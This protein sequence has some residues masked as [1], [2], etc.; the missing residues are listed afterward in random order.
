[1]RVP[2]LIL[3]A[4][5][6]ALVSCK[7][8]ETP[9]SVSGEGSSEEAIPDDGSPVTLRVKW[10]LGNRYTQRMEVTGDTETFVPQMPKPML[11]R[12]NLNQDYGITVLGER[13]K[14]G[15]ELELEVEST[16]IDVTMD[17][18]PVV[19]LDT[20]AEA[21]P[22]ETANP[23]IAAFRQIVGAK[24]KFVLNESNHVE[25]V[26][27][28]KE[29]AAKATSAGNPQGRAAMQSMFTEDYFK[30]MVDFQ[31]G[32]PAKAVKVGDSWPL[33]TDLAM[34]I[35]AVTLDINYT[36]KGWENREKRKCAA[37]DF[38]GTMSSKGGSNTGPAGMS[39][40]I[41]SGK[42][43]GKEWF[44]PELGSMIETVIHQDMVLHMSMPMGRAR[45]NA[46]GAGGSRSITNNTKQKITIK[47]VE[48]VSAAK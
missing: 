6:L 42:L 45:T 18:K 21:G 34:P 9:K 16:E 13:A 8:S 46:A 32:L 38:T 23:M 43:S 29:F 47:L 3:F 17:G 14:G 15:R 24:I 19:N 5:L 30:Q 4:L 41:Q 26:E 35:G 27:G 44:D 7:K 11:Q 1:M 36:L 10:P 48:V 25:K 22:T 31:R 20:R 28:V 12:L 33:K 37:I 2:C 40:N 39:M